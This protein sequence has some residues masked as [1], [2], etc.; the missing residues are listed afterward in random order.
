MLERVL[1]T[2]E[3][4]TDQISRHI[5]RVCKIWKHLSKIVL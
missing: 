2:E 5:F 1:K 3:A 4:E